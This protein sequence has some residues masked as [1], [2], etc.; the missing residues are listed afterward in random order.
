MRKVILDVDT[1]TDD[2]IAVMVAIQAP[3]LEVVGLCSVHGNAD[4]AYTTINTMRA[5]F[6]AGGAEIPVYPGAACPMV[7]GLYAQRRSL[8]E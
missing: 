6:A 4:V 2:A 5:A 7:K 8:V 1:G 3:E